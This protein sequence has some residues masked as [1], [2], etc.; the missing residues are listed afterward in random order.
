MNRKSQKPMS[1]HELLARI[2][3]DEETSMNLLDE[4]PP[5][6]LTGDLGAAL[7]A[8]YQSLME[9]HRFTPGQ[10]VTWKPGLKTHRLPRYGVPA[11]VIEVLETPVFDSERESGSPYFREPND[12]VLGLIWEDGP[13]RGELATYHFDSRRF[14]P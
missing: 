4:E 6:D 5:E 13:C 10:L 14:M 1:S 9:R 12:L 8:R 11:L 7:R 3:L 2:G